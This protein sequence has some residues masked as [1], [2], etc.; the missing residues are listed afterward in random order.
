MSL[1]LLRPLGPPGARVARWIISDPAVEGFGVEI[2]AGLSSNQDRFVARDAAGLAL[3]DDDT[4]W[5]AVENVQA[6]DQ[7][8]W[9]AE[10]HRGPGRDP[11]VLPIP[12]P[13]RGKRVALGAVLAALKPVDDPRWPFR[14]PKALAEFLGAVDSSG[15]SLTAYWGYWVEQSGVARLSGCSLELKVILEVLHHALVF[16][17]LD[18]TNL[19]SFELMARRA[20]Q[21]QRAVKRCP[22]HPTFEGLDLMLSSELDDTGGVVTTKFDAFIAEEQKNRGIILKQER[23]WRDEQEQEAKKYSRGAG[24]A[25]TEDGAGAETR[26]PKAKA[27]PGARASAKPDG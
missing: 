11:R 8:S 3:V 17:R 19:A 4:G 22:R 18:V 13:E 2:E 12:A 27:K 23:L 7:A 20:L 14:G 9:L 10:K 24:R 5:V 25:G 6:E 16:D 21:I 15:M 26:R 1:A